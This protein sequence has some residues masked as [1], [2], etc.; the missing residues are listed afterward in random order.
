MALKIG[1]QVS[2]SSYRT[3]YWPWIP[4]DQLPWLTEMQVLRLYGKSRQQVEADIKERGVA[5]ETV[6]GRKDRGLFFNPIQM[7]KLYHL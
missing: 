2:K 5:T 3:K 6:A 1:V 4:Y 7:H